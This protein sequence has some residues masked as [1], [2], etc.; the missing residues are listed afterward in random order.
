MNNKDDLPKTDLEEHIFVLLADKNGTIVSINN[1]LSSDCG[2]NLTDVI[3]QPFTMLF[4][5]EM[6]ETVIEDLLNTVS[7]GRTW[8]GYLKRLNK[9]GESFW[10]HSTISPMEAEGGF[11]SSC[12]KA[13]DE[14]ISD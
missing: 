11:L 4:H 1:K 10:V 8:K 13:L 9:A 2:Y 6:I 7:S 3:G 12:R 14:E 5:P